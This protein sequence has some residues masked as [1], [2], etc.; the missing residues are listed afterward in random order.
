MPPGLLTPRGDLDCCFVTD[1]H[2]A[3]G[4][5]KSLF[6]ELAS[7]PPEAVFIGG[8]LLAGGFLKGSGHTGDTISDVLAAGFKSLQER[9]GDAY[10]Q[11]F[12]ILGNDD[13]KSSESLLKQYEKQGLWHYCNQ[14]HYQVGELIVY[15]YSW[16]PPTPFLNKDWERYDVSRYL[17]IGCIAPEEGY[18]TT[19]FSLADASHRTISEDLAELTYDCDLS[20]AIFLFHAPPY[21][22]GLDRAA[23]DGKMI[24][25][26]PLDVHVGS[27]AIRRFIEEKQPLITLHGH[28]HE[29]YELT[30]VWKEHIGHTTC[31]SAAG[32]GKALTLVRFNTDDP[33]A[34]ERL[35]IN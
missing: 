11:V 31:L 19:K 28:V 17:D 23:L 4:K 34:A 3:A 7:Q 24:D 20:N 6:R 2:G 26:A 35:T 18:H 29:S 9:L 15:G 30:G 12:I 10:P 22:T 16:V 14:K 5:Y 21:D 13:P 25:H 8:D 27:I 1:L 32:T 33:A